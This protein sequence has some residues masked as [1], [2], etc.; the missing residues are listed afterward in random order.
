MFGFNTRMGGEKPE[1]K[2]QEEEKPDPSENVIPEAVIPKPPSQKTILARNFEAYRDQFAPI[3]DVVD[4]WKARTT[5]TA[6]SL[7]RLERTLAHIETLHEKQAEIHCDL[8]TICPGAEFSTRFE[9]RF[10]QNLKE[11]DDSAEV[12][13]ELINAYKEKKEME[14]LKAM[15]ETRSRSSSRDRGSPTFKLEK[16]KLKTFSG[17][18]T[19]GKN[20]M[21]I[22]R[23]QYIRTQNF[24]MWKNWC[25]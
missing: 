8:F 7:T 18:T 24:L 1:E 2:V 16:L 3:K 12:V 11:L 19:S 9:S 14:A 4:A 23:L 10:R 22:S 21:T 20:S 17:T 25:I 15:K 5:K 6:P 13:G